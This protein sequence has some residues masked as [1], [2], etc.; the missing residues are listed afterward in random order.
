VSGVRQILTE[1]L[2]GEPVT[3]VAEK[4]S[5]VRRRTE[6]T[7]IYQW[8]G[9]TGGFPPPRPNPTASRARNGP[10]NHHAQ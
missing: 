10:R 1:L 8:H 2:R 9:A 5:Q 3:G 4:A 7:R 6:E